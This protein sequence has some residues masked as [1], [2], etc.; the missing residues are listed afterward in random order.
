MDDIPAHS[1]CLPR[2]SLCGVFSSSTFGCQPPARVAAARFVG[3]FNEEFRTTT[4][5]QTGSR[6]QA[7]TGQF[8]RSFGAAFPESF[9][10]YFSLQPLVPAR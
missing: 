9:I 6:R 10:L 3:D 7:A 1:R 4:A 5:P 8:A 2:I